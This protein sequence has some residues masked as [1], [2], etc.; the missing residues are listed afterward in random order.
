MSWTHA[1]DTK[2]RARKEH[3][4]DLCGQ[5]I[6]VGETHIARRGFDEG[7]LTIR[8]H[9]AC[10]VETKDWDQGDW[11]G[12]DEGEFNQYMKKLAAQHSDAAK[13]TP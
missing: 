3:D 7:P 4:C 11:E 10:E 6:V 9:I 13:N 2:P 12:R 1:S 8:M 5:P